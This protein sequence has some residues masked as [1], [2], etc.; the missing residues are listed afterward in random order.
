[1]ELVVQEQRGVWLKEDVGAVLVLRVFGGVAR[2][3]T[4][5]E[6]GTPH[7]AVAEGG[8]L[9]V[10]TQGIDGFHAHAVESD[11]LLESLRVVFAARV[12]HRDGF[13]HLALRYAS[14]IVAHGDAQVLLHVDFYAVARLHLKLVDAVV[15]DLF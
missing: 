11:G 12:K 15:N 1:M 4:L 3:L 2:E 8:H 14:A 13:N 7:L 9:E 5:S 6:G 10:L